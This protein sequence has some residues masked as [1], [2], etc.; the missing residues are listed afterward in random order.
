MNKFPCQLVKCEDIWSHKSQK[1]KILPTQHILWPFLSQTSS[2]SD[3]ALIYEWKGHVA[4]ISKIKRNRS[5]TTFSVPPNFQ[6]I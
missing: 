6:E 3:W 1:N 4:R 2:K 5:S